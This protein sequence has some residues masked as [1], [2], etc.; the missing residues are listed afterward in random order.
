M[1]PFYFLR[2]CFD[3]QWS[4]KIQLEYTPQQWCHC[5]SSFLF[6][7]CFWPNN[8]AF[9]WTTLLS[10]LNDDN[11]KTI[12]LNGSWIIT[13]TN[14]N[15]EI[16]LESLRSFLSDSVHQFAF[17]FGDAVLCLVAQSCP[18]L[19]DPMDCSPPGA[20]VYVGPPGKNTGVG[21]HALIQGIF[22]TLGS[23]PGLPHCRQIL[24]HLSHQGDTG[25]CENSIITI[26]RNWR[27][28]AEWMAHS[29]IMNV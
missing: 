11:P 6:W 19:C 13:S 22:P 18:T 21:C 20:S 16:N 7:P 2:T 9:L 17:L 26:I 23:N 8:L 4:I 10:K 24:Y 27:F 25:L 1:F 14:K 28:I 3:S 12:C 5:V 29:I 15:R